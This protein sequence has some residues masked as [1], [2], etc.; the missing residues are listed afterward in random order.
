MAAN[1]SILTPLKL[2]VHQQEKAQ[3]AAATGHWSLDEDEQLAAALKKNGYRS[4]AKNPRGFWPNVA[5]DVDGRS[6]SQCQTHFNKL[7]LSGRPA[8]SSVTSNK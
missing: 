3:A 6:G 2:G 1:K 7:K 8:T 4:S 5:K